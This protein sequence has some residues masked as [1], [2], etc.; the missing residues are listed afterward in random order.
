MDP[1][2]LNAA[3]A[4]FAADLTVA[5][6]PTV[7]DAV[8]ESHLDLLLDLQ[9]ARLRWP[10]VLKLLKLAGARRPDG[11]DLSPDQF[12]ASVSRAKRRRAART[13]G[14]AASFA[15]QTSGRA[16][17]DRPMKPVRSDTRIAEQPDGGQRALIQPQTAPL[18][19]HRRDHLDPDLSQDDLDAVRRRL[20]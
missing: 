12:R 5:G 1:D 20:R 6:E 4:R 10:A 17:P 19:P 16:K 13:V 18:A 14:P 2:Q 3:L 15:Q 9:A 7:F 11:A 8:V